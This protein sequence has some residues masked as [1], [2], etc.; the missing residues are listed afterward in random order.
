MD[1]FDCDS[2][3]SSSNDS[4]FDPGIDQQHHSATRIVTRSAVNDFPAPLESCDFESLTLT[5]GGYHV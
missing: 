2:P 3:R 5:K 1:L 4:V